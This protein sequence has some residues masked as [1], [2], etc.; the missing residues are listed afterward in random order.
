MPCWVHDTL[1]LRLTG[2]HVCHG[3]PWA[4]DGCHIGFQLDTVMS[5]M[6]TIRLGWYMAVQSKQAAVK[7]WKN[8]NPKIN[9]PTTILLLQSK[10]EMGKKI[11]V[12]MTL[13]K[14]AQFPP[15]SSKKLNL[16]KRRNPSCIKGSSIII[17]CNNGSYM[18]TKQSKFQ[19]VSYYLDKQTL[20]TLRIKL[21]AILNVMSLN[22]SILQSHTMIWPGFKFERPTECPYEGRDAGFTVTHLKIGMY[23]HTLITIL[24]KQIFKIFR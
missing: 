21:N 11:S 9:H 23:N 10:E 24:L 16:Q 2:K 1:T 22:I 13:N 12:S 6:L 4:T 15:S 18:R 17:F 7:A 3:L 5:H 20:S 8:K 14:A 19:L